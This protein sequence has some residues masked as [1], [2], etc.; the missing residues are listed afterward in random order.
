MGDSLRSLMR[1]SSLPRLEA[2]MLWQH[3]LQV[4]RVWLIAHDTDTLPPEQIARFRK[5]EQRRLH[6]EP[7]AYILG[8][9]EFMSREFRIT[10]DVLIPRPETELLVELALRFLRMREQQTRDRVAQG[11]TPVL[12]VLDLGTGSGAIAVSLALECPAAQVTATDI[13]PRALA[14]AVENARILGAR[15]EFFC[16]TWYDALLRPDNTDNGAGPKPI[17]LANKYDLIVSNPPYIAAADTHL[18]QG[19]VRFEPAQALT[20]GADGLSDLQAIAQGAMQWLK[21]GGGLYMEHGWDQSA[22]VR[23]ILLRS[24]FGQVNSSADLAGI[25]RVTGG[26]YN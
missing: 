4:P 21:P 1:V 12:R 26:L 23:D 22:A 24:G 2:Q 3:V 7:M 6:G 25:E 8:S 10:P 20:D 18:Q 13:S 16:G 15:V 19:D 11:E 5:L 14:I 17:S 9:R